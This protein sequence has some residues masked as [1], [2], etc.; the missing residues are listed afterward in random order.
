MAPPGEVVPPVA[1]ADDEVT[2]VPT[3]VMK[4]M[5]GKAKA[6]AKGK[7]AMKGKAKAKAKKLML[8]DGD[9]DGEVVQKER[10]PK[11]S[12]FRKRLLAE[13]E[14]SGKTLEQGIEEFRAALAGGNEQTN[15]TDEADKAQAAQEEQ[16]RRDYDDA[17]A[18]VEAAMATELEKAAAYRS[19]CGERDAKQQAV[20]RLRNELLETQKAEA[21]LSIQALN[22]ARMQEL[23]EKKRTATEAAAKAKQMFVEQKQREKEALEVTKR[24]LDKNKK[25][26]Q[27][28]KQALKAGRT[29]A[30]ST[31]A[32]A[33]GTDIE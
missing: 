26:F 10:A 33:A 29:A 31:P 2:A 1:A 8:A 14:A 20:Q 6:K 19:R 28:Q 18:R 22:H 13:L 24:L 25:D 17:R 21:M 7:K 30:A 16:A 5:K 23:E 11:S 32:E 15:A 4:V 27:A 3:K 9:V 12:G